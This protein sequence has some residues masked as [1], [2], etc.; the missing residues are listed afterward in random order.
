MK[1]MFQSVQQKVQAPERVHA[2]T[3]RF[4]LVTGSL[5]P[6]IVCILDVDDAFEV[7]AEN[8]IYFLQVSHPVQSF[9]PAT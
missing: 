7:S 5:Y 6:R 3:S 1:P 8:R 2:Q 4:K 9:C